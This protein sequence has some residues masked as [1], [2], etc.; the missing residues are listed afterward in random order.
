MHIGKIIYNYRKEHNLSMDKFAEKSGLSKSYIAML[1]KNLNPSTGKTITPTIDVIKKIANATM[2]DFDDLF[3][4]M[5][6]DTIISVNT[7]SPTSDEEIYQKL[8]IDYIKIPLYSSICCGNGGFNDDNILEYIPI[9]NKGL[10][11]NKTYFGQYAEGN[12]MKEAGIGDGDLLIFE[13]VSKVDNG[14]IGCFCI[15]DNRAMCKK[16]REQ[17]GIIILQP[18]NSN[19]EPIIIDP[20]NNN[21][22]CVGKLKKVIKDFDWDD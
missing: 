3:S 7:L 15:D 2:M 22:R 8:K 6:D 18:M 21:F 4:I 5:D 19:F 13:K 1:E 12:S 17:N 10:V 14:V 20:L 9:P 16:Y 11:S